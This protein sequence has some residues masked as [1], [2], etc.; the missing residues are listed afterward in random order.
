MTSA[1]TVSY[2]CFL[3]W[4][5]RSW[6]AMVRAFCFWAVLKLT[7]V[8]VVAFLFIDILVLALS[9]RV[10]QFQDYFCPLE[11][12]RVTGPPTNAITSQISLMSSLSL[13]LLFLSFS[14]ACCLYLSLLPLYPPSLLIKAHDRPRLGQFLHWE[15][16]DRNRDIWNS[17]HF[18]AWWVLRFSFPQPLWQGITAFNAFS[19]SRWSQVPFQC[20]SIPT[21]MS[22][23]ARLLFG[24]SSPQTT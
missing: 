19:T 21:G 2:L 9:T 1:L 12:Y 5:G 8:C 10:N 24:P 14:S 11:S 4:A 7:G 20:D 3:L 16:A 13:F 15:A 22:N 18:L 17:E 6:Q 23:L